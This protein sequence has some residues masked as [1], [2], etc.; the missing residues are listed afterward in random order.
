[1]EEKTVHIKSFGCQMN[2]LDTNLVAAAMAEAGFSLAADVKSADAVLINT[3]S[4]RAHAEERV[5]SHLGHLKHLKQTRP[6]VVVAVFGCMAQRLGAELL[7]HPAV[8]IVCGPAQIPH[9]ADLVNSAIAGKPHTVA[10]TDKIRA[11]VS[12]DQSKL[13]DDFEFTH[14]SPENH[15]P[16]QAFVRVMRG[17]NKFCTYCIVPY[18]RGAE[19][20]RPPWDIVEQV[21]KLAGTG[22][23]QVTLLGQ[24]V[25]SYEY[26]ADGKTYRLADLLYMVSEVESIKWIRFITGHPKDFDVSIFQAIADLPKICPYLHIPAQSGSDKILKAMNRGYTADEYL[27]LIAQARQIV[28]DIAVAGDFIVGFCGET[29]EDFRA[30]VELVKKVRYKN[31]FVFKY[32]P[33]PGTPADKKIIDDVPEDVKKQRNIELLEVQ[34]KISEEDNARFLDTTVEVLVE[35]PS[36]KA[37]L[38]DSADGTNPQLIARTATDYIVVFNGPASLAGQFTKVKI[39]KTSPL[40]LFGQLC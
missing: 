28:P 32:S 33:R 38:N 15:L 5:F 36:K 18:V 14:D 8:D 34:N 30:T 4:V 29:D 11:K 27:A 39:T 7:A 12:A 22:V 24:T 35:G 17:C 10:I 20:S 25:N 6:Q 9:L 16:S 21:K 23:K 13:L 3:C 1:M 26:K 2:K 19:S 37:H 40:T 31:C